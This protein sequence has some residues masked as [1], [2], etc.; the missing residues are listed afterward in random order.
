MFLLLKAEQA[1]DHGR[2]D[3]MWLLRLGYKSQ[4]SFSL[5]LYRLSLVEP[6][7]HTVRKPSSHMEMSCGDTLTCSSAKVLANSQYQSPNIWVR[8]FPDDSNPWPLSLPGKALTLWS[9]DKLTL[10]SPVLNSEGWL[11]DCC[12]FKALYF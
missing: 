9:R 7:Y 6:S 1:C 4:Y 8:M 3:F 10:L 11:N 5:A 2:I 12:S